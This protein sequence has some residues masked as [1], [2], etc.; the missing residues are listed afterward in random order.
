MKSKLLKRALIGAFF[1]LETSCSS[2]QGSWES[3]TIADCS[4]LYLPT[5]N[6]FRELELVFQKEAGEERLY[7]NVYGSPFQLDPN[8]NV[9]LSLTIDQE[10]STYLVKPL[11][12][13]QRLH[14]PADAEIATIQALKQQKTVDIQVGRY[15]KKVAY[16][17][18]QE[19]YKKFNE[20][21]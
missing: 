8:G 6:T 21:K 10:T 17:Q 19:E 4:R 18:F 12:G 20:A 16:S 5:Q 13:N 2:P 14:F 11:K 15:H 1:F 7:L 9:L 3:A